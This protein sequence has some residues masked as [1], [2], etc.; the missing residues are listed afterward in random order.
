MSCSASDSFETRGFVAGDQPA[1]DGALHDFFAVEA[2]AVVGDFDHHLIGLVKCVQANGAARRFSGSDALGGGFDAVVGGVANQ[3]N[4]RLGKRIEN[5]FIQ[6]GG[7]AGDF[8]GDVFAALLGDIA[9]D[10]RKAAEKLL[11]GNHANLHHGFLQ[12]R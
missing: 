3:M 1:F 10:A 9:N 5:A 8:D 6:I 12:D 11:D 2:A 4:E 7:L